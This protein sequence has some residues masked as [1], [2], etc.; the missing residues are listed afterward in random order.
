MRI[1]RRE[2]TVTEHQSAAHLTVRLARG[3][4]ASPDEGACVVEL[5]SMLAGE[6][7]S[8]HPSTVCPAVAAFL[9][10]YNDHVDEARRHDL[11]AVASAIV[12][13]RGDAELTLLRARRIAL[14]ALELRG[15]RTWLPQRF[16][17]RRTR[18]TITT[19]RSA[20]R[21]AARA[22]A[23]AAGSPSEA[24]LALMDELLS[25]GQPSHVPLPAAN[26]AAPVPGAAAA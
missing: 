22:G 23:L 19:V 14:W 9:R 26:A 10:A 2:P 6:P 24:T 1:A 5:A 20:E 12:A 21:A 8:D 25:M 4:H 7:F 17:P 16:W 15:R 18:P 11:Y 13:S 3:P